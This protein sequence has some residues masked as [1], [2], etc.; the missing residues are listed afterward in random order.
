MFVFI[1]QALY[2]LNSDFSYQSF[3][4]SYR[5]KLTCKSVLQFKESFIPFIK[6][7][8]YKVINFKKVQVF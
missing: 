1:L 7:S 3:S 2:L 8:N 5:L 6:G 4:F